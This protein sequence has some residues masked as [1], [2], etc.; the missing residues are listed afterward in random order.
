MNV[1]VLPV[2]GGAFVS[3]LAAI[4]HLCEAGF[5]PDVSFA[6]SGGNVA[7]YIAA[8]ARW[9]WP[10]IKRIAEDLTQDL[11]V[12]PWSTIGFVSSILGYFN[13]DM[14]NHGK[15]VGEFLASH[16][17]S[18]SIREHEIW[19]GAYNK[20]RHKF[21]LFCNRSPCDS[22]FKELDFDHEL[23]QTLPPIYADGDLNMLAKACLASASIPAVVPPQVINGEHYVDGGIFGAS[24]MTVLHEPLFRKL[25]KKREPLH[26]TYLN[27]LDLSTA[28]MEHA[29]N[30]LDTSKQA[31]EEVV[32]SNIVNDRFSAYSCIRR[33]QGEDHVVDFPCNAEN[34]EKVRQVREKIPGSLLEIYPKV[35]LMLNI[36]NFTGK[37]VV[38][39][40]DANYPHC[41]C[42]FRWIAEEKDEEEIY[43]ILN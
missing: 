10:R 15:G 27:S 7:T 23:T 17:T 29:K 11:F 28:E 4:E 33:Y 22:L 16:F 41:H 21:R 6:S 2:S 42:R 20:D 1:L 13:G 38:K 25:R 34:L 43:S 8:A 31:I 12:R 5:V 26:I 37:D 40:I 9:K 36:T 19:T 3:Q 24:P 39:A 35:N 30:I 14:Y 18:D 32:R